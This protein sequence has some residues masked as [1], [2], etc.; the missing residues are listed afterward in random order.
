MIKIESVVVLVKL[1]NGNIHSLQIDNVQAAVILDISVSSKTLK[2]NEKPL[3]GI[4]IENMNLNI[5]Y[6]TK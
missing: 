4:T 2:V 3:E 5:E 1:D 6:K